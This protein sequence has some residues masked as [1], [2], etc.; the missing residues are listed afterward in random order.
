MYEIKT[1]MDGELMK[2]KA[3]L[4]HKGQ[5]EKHFLFFSK[6]ISIWITLC[7]VSFCFLE[8]ILVYFKFVNWKKED[9]L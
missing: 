6:F 4:I 9:K 2:I 7:L 3:Y 8:V 1:G 5:L